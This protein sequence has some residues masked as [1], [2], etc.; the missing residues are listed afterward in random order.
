[1]KFSKLYLLLILTNP[2]LKAD[3]GSFIQISGSPFASPQAP[4]GIGYSPIVS[5]NLFLAVTK[6]FGNN[7]AIFSVNQLTGAISQ[8][9]GSPFATGNL[10]IKAVYS[11]VVSGNLFLGVINE[12]GNSVSVYAVNQTTGVLTPVAGSPFATGNIPFDLAFSFASGNLFAA[13][14]NNI[15]NNVTVYSVNQI[16]GVFTPVAGSPFAAGA[17][18]TGV[19]FSPVISGNVFAAVANSNANSVSVYSVNQI[20]GVFTPVA[21][22]P[23][24][25]GSSPSSVSFSPIISGNLYLAVS[26]VLDSTISMYSVDP[27]TGALTQVAGSPVPTDTN[28]VQVVFSP[29]LIDDTAFVAVANLNG[30]TTNNYLVDKATGSLTQINGSPFPTDGQAAQ[31]M[32]FS[33]IVS[34]GLFAGVANS[35]G[36]ISIFQVTLPESTPTWIISQP[37][38]YKLGDNYQAVPAITGPIIQI[39]ASGV[40]LDLGDYIINQNNDTTGVTGISIDP[41]LTDVTIK[42]GIIRN[43]TLTGITINQNC[44]RIVLENITCESCQTNGIVLNGGAGAITDCQILD[45]RLLNCCSIATPG[46]AL[47]VNQGNNITVENCIISGINTTNSINCVSLSPCTFSTFNNILIQSNISSGLLIGMF[48]AGSSGNKFSN[49]FIKNNAGTN[50]FTGN[51]VVNS[52]HNIYT[53]CAVIGNSATSA[54]ASGFDITS[55][56]NLNAN[57]CKSLFNTSAASDAIGFRIA[58]SSVC[59]FNNCLSTC[60]FSNGAAFN[61]QGF[62]LSACTGITLNRC[63]SSN[64]IS[65][66]NIGIGLLIAAGIAS[67]NCTVRDSLFHRNNGTGAATSFGV[68]ILSGSNNLFLRNVGFNNG[69]TSAN[70]FSGVP[71]GSVITPAAP[72]TNNMNTAGNYWN[73]VSVAT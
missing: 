34:G 64:N 45:C 12:F 53:N 63:L 8:I 27:T 25:A 1:M 43:A 65:T 16:T 2:L 41:G 20:T 60:H 62:Q 15:T 14:P 36:S 69:T 47:S 21:G 57:N 67:V 66:T 18:P 39:T 5:G 17:G 48:V 4:Y 59:N 38:K 29:Q 30:D 46:N 3:V 71:G 23:F 52:N 51:V 37:G 28:P 33:P 40:E 31:G 58:A 55:C 73:N 50:G 44:S 70:Q 61:A 32:A 10:P 68:R 35:G 6:Q 54:S 26:N 24:A 42:N 72:Q 19:S 22:S 56:A 49:I 9:G 7:V 11:P 13:V